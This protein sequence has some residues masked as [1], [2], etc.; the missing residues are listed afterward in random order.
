MLSVFKTM[1]GTSDIEVR[2][3]KDSATR[4][5]CERGTRSHTHMRGHQATQ[6]GTRDVIAP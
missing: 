5:F 1:S 6:T 4:F 3:E 2:P